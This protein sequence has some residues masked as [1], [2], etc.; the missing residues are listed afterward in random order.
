M[1]KKNNS[2]KATIFTTI[3][4]CILGLFLIVIGPMYCNDLLL[5][6]GISVLSGTIV[7]LMSNI[8]V[9]RHYRIKDA[10]A[11][12]IRAEILENKY[13]VEA[14]QKTLSEFSISLAD[15]ASD[16]YSYFKTNDGI[17]DG[18][19]GQGYFELVRT[20]NRHQSIGLIDDS[21]LT[22][23]EANTLRDTQL[24]I[25]PLL[26]N[27][28]NKTYSKIEVSQLS[29]TMLS[30]VTEITLMTCRLQYKIMEIASKL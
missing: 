7:G 5:N 1:D 18:V 28:E 15:I 8:A 14:Q 25:I 22:E 12:K 9:T 3:A 17:S 16:I 13:K 10:K 24:L 20:L 30:K 11:A 19:I 4:F 29:L 26:R 23:D 2:N 21:L 27:V 6:I